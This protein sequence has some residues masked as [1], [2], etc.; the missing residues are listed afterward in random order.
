[1]I[2]CSRCGYENA[3]GG[4]FCS[5]CGQKLEKPCPSCGKP[6]P[7]DAKFCASCGANLSGAP[8]GAGQKVDNS[9]NVFAGD[10]SGSYNTSNTY[11]NHTSVVNNVYNTTVDNDVACAV[12]GR[13]IPADSKRVFQCTRCGRHFCGEHMDMV[14]HICHTCAAEHKES[15]LDKAK[16]E[17]KSGFYDSALT[18]F[19]KAMDNNADDPDA[20]YYA[21]IALFG[22]KKAFV[23]QRTVID[24]ALNYINTAISMRPKGIY[25]Y[26]LAYIKYDYF[27]RKYLNTSPNYRQAAALAVKNGVTAQQISDM[28]SLM[29]VSRPSEI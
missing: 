2:K 28:Y 7:P 3:D 22:G 9:G 12:C 1:M 25:Y 13:P 24:Q 4:L 19:R 21:A 6:C 27:E 23:Q 17:L 15:S 20:Y 26:L 11:N 29:K 18:N 8:N 14:T 10:V 5:G 16:G